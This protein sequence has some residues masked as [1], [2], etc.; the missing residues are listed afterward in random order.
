MSTINSSQKTLSGVMADFREKGYIED[1]NLQPDKLVCNSLER[2]YHPNEFEVDHIHRFE[3]ASSADDN[4]IL[5]AIS[6]K[7]DDTKG[8]LVDAYGAYADPL[9]TDMVKRLNYRPED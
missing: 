1:F 8:L 2:T 7:K 3:G 9:T 5:F 4:S 6:S